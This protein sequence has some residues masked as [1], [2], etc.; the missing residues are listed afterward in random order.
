MDISTAESSWCL[1]SWLFDIQTGDWS[2]VTNHVLLQWFLLAPWSPPEFLEIQLFK[3]IIYLDIAGYFNL[4]HNHSK[5]LGVVTSNR[6]PV[7]HMYLVVLIG[8]ILS[9]SRF[10][11]CL[12]QALNRFLN[13]CSRHSPIHFS[14]ST[15]S[16]T[17]FVKENSAHIS[18]TSQK[19]S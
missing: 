19:V 16:D 3:A 8:S 12:Y 7:K 13:R 10:G 14:S 1:T 15:L 5:L 17:Q 11:K 6:S 9:L 4:K 18:L 2:K